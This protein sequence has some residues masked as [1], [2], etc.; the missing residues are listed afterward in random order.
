MMQTRSMQLKQLIMTNFDIFELR[1]RELLEK[2]NKKMLRMF[3]GASVLAFGTNIALGR[4]TRGRI[5]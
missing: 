1:D 3:L 2:N 5:F 4:F